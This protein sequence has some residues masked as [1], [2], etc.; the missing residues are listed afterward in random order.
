[1]SNNVGYIK[2]I[3]TSRFIGWPNK[4][5]VEWAYGAEHGPGGHPL[6]N[7]HERIADTVLRAI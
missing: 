7:G 4:G 5:I 1:M 6:A 2:Q 3:D